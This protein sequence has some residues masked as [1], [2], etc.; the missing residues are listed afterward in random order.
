MANFNE[1]DDLFKNRFEG[2]KDHSVNPSEQWVA[3]EQQLNTGSS[4]T[5]TSAGFSSMKMLSMAA[6]VAAI[7]S[8]GLIS[9]SDVNHIPQQAT[10]QSANETDFSLNKASFVP[11]VNEDEGSFGFAAIEAVETR[12]AWLLSEHTIETSSGLAIQNS[13]F[14]SVK[15]ESTALLASTTVDQSLEKNTDRTIYDDSQ[16]S[17]AG[18]RANVNKMPSLSLTVRSQELAEHNNS[19]DFLDYAAKAGLGSDFFMRVGVRFGNGESNNKF[20]PNN[21]T[22]NA[23]ASIGFKKAIKDNMGWMVELAYLRR[24][25]NGLERNQNLEVERLYTAFNNSFN[26][27]ANSEEITPSFTI[28]RSII[29][30]RLDYVQLPVS[31]YYEASQ[32]LSFN[33]GAYADFLLRASNATYL[34]YNQKDYV[35]RNPSEDE[36]NSKEGLNRFRYGLSAGANY[37]IMSNLSLDLRTMVPLNSPFNSTAEVC[38]NRGAKQSL[39]LMIGLRYSI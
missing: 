3:F 17:Y 22:A 11:F 26:A 31:M 4:T 5:K 33:A 9:Q 30:T 35:S 2:Y 38:A 23:M 36:L 12:T 15:Q 28:D 25:G 37:E 14:A 21:W 13:D 10:S 24:S 1:I 32:K 8:V 20:Q 39:D 18:L 6:S 7:I 34:V 29:A 16:V 27:G 19:L